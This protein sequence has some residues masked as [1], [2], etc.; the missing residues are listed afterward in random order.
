MF[1]FITII[2]SS[3]ISGTVYS[4]SASKPIQ[5]AEILILELRKS[6]VSNSEG[7]YFFKNI[8][9]GKYKIEVYRTGY[10]PQMKRVR[11]YSKKKKEVNFILKEKPLKS[12]GVKITGK[13][14]DLVSKNIKST[15]IKSHPENIDLPHVL[16]SIAG[17]TTITDFSSSLT[18][19][20][21]APDENL[22][23]INGIEIPYPVHFGWVGGEGG[24]V[25]ILNTRLIRNVEFYTAGFPARFGDKLSSVIDIDL[26]NDLKNRVNVD[27]N[28]A[29]MNLT[30]EN[31]LHNNIIL[32]GNLRRSHLEIWK[33]IL[34]LESL[35]PDYEDYMVKV[36]FEP[37]INNRF[38]LIGIIAKDKLYYSSEEEYNVCGVEIPPLEIEWDNTQNIWAFKWKH[39]FSSVYSSLLK[40]SRSE[41]E[42]Y[43]F[44]KNREEINAFENVSS[45]SSELF[46]EHSDRNKFKVGGTYKYLDLFHYIQV[47]P[48]TTPT[49]ILIPGNIIESGNI[50]FKTSLFFEYI[51]NPISAI[52][53]NLGVRA[54]YSD[55]LGDEVI[56][57]RIQANYDLDSRNVLLLSGGVYHQ[58][59]K[60]EDIARNSDL[61]FEKAVHYNIGLKHFL[62]SNNGE[63]EFDIYWKDYSN[64]CI[65]FSDSSR[66]IGNT[67]KGCSYGLEFSLNRVVWERVS[68]DFNYSYSISMFIE[69]ENLYYFNWDQR[70]IIN[71][72]ADY[73]I[74]TSFKASL[75]W[76]YA[77]GKPYTPVL[78]REQHPVV[79][80]W[81]PVL[82][83]S[84]SARYP[85][86]HR[87][88][89]RLQYD[90][91]LWNLKSSLYLALWNVYDHKNILTY[92]W[93]NDYVKKNEIS[94]ISF[95]PVGGIELHF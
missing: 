53:L 24:G 22:T 63:V 68:L 9:S 86:Y 56:S 88:D 27:I 69:N 89:L 11:I 48:D 13:R 5:D 47:F 16:A 36:E 40:I 71:I 52:T 28:S 26:E 21:G 29:D 41:T 10:Q 61:K 82:G 64:L 3:S 4:E 8:R 18:V 62:N 32:T 49:Y 60:Y 83:E 80:K 50:S 79:G 74:T 2:F 72:L 31:K 73:K 34:G 87:L 14:I 25:S 65:P 15:Y 17:V 30:V 20:G 76:R 66:K 39:K 43:G 35:V 7:K 95:L 12:K 92:R 19:R 54:I 1:L 46:Y 45:I 75:K 84:N 94:Q 58:R 78:G 6:T 44:Q 37:E 91:E 23:L 90:T 55:L 42:S 70:H 38:E 77:S 81:L 57:P 67:G 93:D 85:S 59:P 33:G 51:C